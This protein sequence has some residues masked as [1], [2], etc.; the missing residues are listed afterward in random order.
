MS[1]GDFWFVGDYQDVKSLKEE[2]KI[3]QIV[4]KCLKIDPTPR[5]SGREWEVDPSGAIF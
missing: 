1:E 3:K 5:E 2:R 4:E